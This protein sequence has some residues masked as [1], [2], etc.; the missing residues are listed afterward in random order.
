LWSFA[1]PRATSKRREEKRREEKRRE[2]KRTDASGDL[3]AVFQPRPDASSR[4]SAMLAPPVGLCAKFAVPP[5]LNATAVDL[6]RFRRGVALGIR[7]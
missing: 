7:A 4:R 5:A 1:T 6:R 3:N 2:E